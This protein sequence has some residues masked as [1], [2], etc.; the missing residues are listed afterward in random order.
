MRKVTCHECKK[1]YDYDEDGFCPACGAFNVPASFARIDADGN[2]VWQEGNDQADW[3]ST[4]NSPISPDRIDAE[5]N[6]VQND[7]A[8][9][10]STV[11]LEQPEDEVDQLWGKLQQS[12]KE[13]DFRKWHGRNLRMQT[14]GR[15]SRKIGVKQLILLVLGFI[16]LLN[17]LS[18]AF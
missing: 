7:Q 13:S 10:R 8:A 11:Q 12:F 17:V 9:W 5:G 4:V 14:S 18:L 2:V 16:I 3:R 15:N 6:L 1:R